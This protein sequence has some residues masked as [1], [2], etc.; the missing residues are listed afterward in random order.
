M[1]NV[2]CTDVYKL[3]PFCVPHHFP[4][5][6]CISNKKLI[7]LSLSL[8][9]TLTPLRCYYYL[10]FR[11]WILGLAHPTSKQQNT[12]SKVKNILEMSKR[13]FRLCRQAWKHQTFYTIIQSNGHYHLVINS[14]WNGQQ[15]KPISNMGWCDP[16]T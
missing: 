16:Q 11:W 14:N 9:L 3:E 4:A 5:I 8:C 10:C 13:W 15:L 12:F 6:C 1:F 2:Q 7:S